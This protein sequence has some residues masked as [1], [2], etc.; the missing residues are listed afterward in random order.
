[1]KVIFLGTGT[2]HGIP[3]IGCDCDCCTSSDTRNQ[4]YRTSIVV[5]SSDDKQVLV[6]TSPE[7]RL[8]AIKYKIKKPKCVLLT[9][10]HADHLHGLDDLRIFAHTITPCSENNF[11]KSKPLKIFANKNTVKDV[12][13]RFSYVFKKTQLGGGK[14]LL[15]LISCE[16][17]T[18]ENPLEIGNLSIIPV[19]MYHGKLKT[20]GWMFKDKNSCQSF[21][22]LTDCSFI[23]DDSL[24]LVKDC[25]HIVIDAL[26]EKFHTTHFNFE[27]AIEFVSK[28]NTKNVYLT[29][30]SH[31]TTHE[32][33]FEIIDELK[34]KFNV[35]EKSIIPAYD[36]LELS[37]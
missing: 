17:F 36:G 3:V 34:E 18:K 10:S 37:I 26:R 23:T 9:H 12:K 22:Y 8:Q 27:Q 13:E 35:K 4:R 25:T 14:P 1:M 6:D 24:E 15:K 5:E 19:P 20:S 28:T 31:E 29:H 32:R 7:F 33:I 30:I 21:A 2:S 16:K 11:Q